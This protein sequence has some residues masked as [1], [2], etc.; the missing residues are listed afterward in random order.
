MN[1][2][3]RQHEHL[4]HHGNHHRQEVH[5][6]RCFLHEVPILPPAL[7]LEN[8][9]DHHFQ[10]FSG[11]IQHGLIHLQC[12]NQ[13]LTLPGPKNPCS[14]HYRKHSLEHTLRYCR[15]RP[16]CCYKGCSWY[17]TPNLDLIQFQQMLNS[18]LLL[19]DMA[20]KKCG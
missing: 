6:Q 14:Y 16:V 2:T 11:L 20:I 15:S 19:L 10:P 7:P 17:R 9:F 13:Q 12:S 18:R 3:C 4:L 1:D 5:R 8:R